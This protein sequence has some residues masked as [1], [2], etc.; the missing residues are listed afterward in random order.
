[1][2]TALALLAVLGLPAAEAGDLRLN[3]ARSTY[4][5]LGPTRAADKVLP[6]DKYVLSF[7][8]EGITIDDEGKARYSVGFD[9]ADASGKV[10][11]KQEPKEQTAQASLGGNSLPAS[12]QLDVGLQAKPGE[13]NLKV[14]VTDLATKKTAEL[15][16]K[17]EVL[18]KGFGMVRLTTSSDQDGRMPVSVPGCGEWLFVHCGIVGF[19]RNDASKQPDVT[20]SMVIKDEQGK[21]TTAKPVTVV[22]NKDV[23]EAAPALPLRQ[24]LVLN[25]AGKFTVELT[26]TDR[27]ANK[28]AT[29]SFPLTVA[30]PR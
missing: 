13:Y 19:T 24:L 23:P 22:V 4:C 10:L 17:A 1:M 9:V 27:F 8:I 21:P 7:D 5:V 18:E 25:R 12:A 26:A 15:T 14:T 29:L 30:S 16:R 11:F 20:L 3:N 28:T 6:G 2:G